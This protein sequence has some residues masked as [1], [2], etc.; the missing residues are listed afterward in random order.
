MEKSPNKRLHQQHEFISKY[1][2]QNRIKHSFI[3]PEYKRN[4]IRN[5]WGN[6]HDKRNNVNTY[7]YKESCSEAPTPWDLKGPEPSQKFVGP[8]II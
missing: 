6:R 8:P 7:I 2:P 3:K 1:N 5:R 4:N